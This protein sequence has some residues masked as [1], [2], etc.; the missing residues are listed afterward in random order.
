MKRIV[1]GIRGRYLRLD[2]GAKM[3]LGY[4]PLV[5]IIV[6]V[7]ASYFFRLDRIMNINE[8]I[9][10][11]DVPA[12]EVAEAMIDTI[13][14]QELYAKRYDILGSREMLEAFSLRGAEFKDGLARLEKNASPGIAERATPL[15]SLHRRYERAFQAG[16]EAVRGAPGDE[17][18]PRPEIRELQDEIIGRLKKITALAR[19]SQ[20]QRTRTMAALERSTFTIMLGLSIA[21]ALVGAGA[22]LLI[23]RDIAGSIGKLKASTAEIAE[24]R[25]DGLQ[26]LDNQDE[27]GD[28][29]R[30]IAEMSR[31]LKTLEALRLDSSPLTHLPGG[32]AIENVLKARIES[33]AP[34]AFCLIDIDNFKAFNDRYGY[35]RG[36]DVLTFTAQSIVD[37]TQ[38]HGDPQ[39]FVGHIGGDD[40][41]VISRPERFEAILKRLI[42]S[43]D[44]H[45][46]TLYDAAD[47]ERGYIEGE[48][49]QGVRV[50]FPYASLSIAV[51]TSSNEHL[52]THL[53]TSEI[54]AALKEYAKTFPGSKYVVDRRANAMAGVTVTG[55]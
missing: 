47:R 29:S 50:R 41:V 22:A 2:I 13:L 10:T 9:L 35:S 16:F 15:S 32:L 43:F 4:L 45:I 31:K 19:Q 8:A 53:R 25:F 48:N 27:L 49:R 46:P 1:S 40:F 52:G 42:A 55:A 20:E 33:G 18:P 5:A 23:T 6:V 39:D 11:Q 30:A 12:A 34:F 17:V 36:N 44:A 38:R 7:S 28:L 3:L 14:S 26:P 37:A 54:A 24:G 21:G 51:V